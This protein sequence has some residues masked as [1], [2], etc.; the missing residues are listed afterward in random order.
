LTS[1]LKETQQ[2]GVIYQETFMYVSWEPPLAS[3][4]N[5]TASEETLIIASRVFSSPNFSTYTYETL[6]DKIVL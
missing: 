2:F 6:L 3:P 5:L 1:I 4:D